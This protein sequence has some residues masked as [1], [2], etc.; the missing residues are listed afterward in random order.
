MG[1]IPSVSAK[2]LMELIKTGATIEAQEQ[3]IALRQAA[4]SLQE[5][6]IALR[7]RIK[8][9]EAGIELDQHL[10]FD[11]E[12]YWR[13]RNDAKP[14]GPF[15]PLCRDVHTK[16]VHL[17]PAG[18]DQNPIWHCKSCGKSF[19]RRPTALEEA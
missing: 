13:S 16:L 11:G 14:E 15:C 10:A 7:Q 4:L 12:V 1:L 6:N 5:E 2:D 8:D 3:I 18:V 19:Q 9:L 17:Y